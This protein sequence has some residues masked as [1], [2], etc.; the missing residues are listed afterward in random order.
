MID[1]AGRSMRA[2]LGTHFGCAIVEGRQDARLEPKY[3][4]IS[5]KVA[6]IPSVCNCG[7]PPYVRVYTGLRRLAKGSAG[8]CSTVMIWGMSSKPPMRAFKSPMI[9][10]AS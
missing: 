1:L 3:I 9:M 2:R 5:P 8:C 7:I 4:H 10:T 6:V